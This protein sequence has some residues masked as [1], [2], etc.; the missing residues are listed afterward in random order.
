MRIDCAADVQVLPQLM[1]RAELTHR[2]LWNFDSRILR[3]PAPT[4]TSSR[5]SRAIS[6]R[7]TCRIQQNDHHAQHR[8]APRTVQ[9]RT[10]DRHEAQQPHDFVV[11]DQR[12]KRGPGRLRA[13][14]NRS[15]MKESGS[16]RRR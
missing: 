16:L 7:R 8:R 10:P 4:S 6:P 15:G 12:G 3:T 14:A 2:D 1:R 9:P 5:V 11:F 13:S